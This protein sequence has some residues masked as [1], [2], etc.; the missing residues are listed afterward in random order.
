MP[1]VAAAIIAFALVAAVAAAQTRI[2]QGPAGQ[3]L[4]VLVQGVWVEARTAAAYERMRLAALLAHVEL[5]LESGWRSTE[6]QARLYELYLAGQGNPAAAPG[7]SNHERGIA[8][9]IRTGLEHG[10]SSADAYE[11]SK[12]FAWLYDNA[13]QYGFTNTEGARVGE[14][15]HW[16]LST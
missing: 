16:V 6:E 10:T 8:L 13:G 5:E 2:V 12:V 1:F 15:W 14:P 9:D 7:T 3:L 4:L 11:N